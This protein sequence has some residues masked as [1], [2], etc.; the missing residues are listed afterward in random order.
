MKTLNLTLFILFFSFITF[1]QTS[2]YGKITAKETGEELIYANIILNKNGVFAAGAST[3]FEG[4]YSIPVDQGTYEI[5]I[6]YT[7]YPDMSITDVIIEAGRGTKLDIKM[8]EEIDLT[9]VVVIE[10]KVPIIKEEHPH[11]CTLTSDQ[12]RNLPTRKITA[13]GETNAGLSQVEQGDQVIIRGKCGQQATDYYID[14]IRVSGTGTL[15]P[16]SKID[17]LQ[18]N[19][20]GG[21][22]ATETVIDTTK[23]N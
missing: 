7:G 15:I 4:N 21:T 8:P 9:K 1:S 16:L 22:P 10:Y 2:I 17:S 23:N 6:S 3:D 14:G 19:L 13:P 20:L 11:S 5:H 12:I 18:K